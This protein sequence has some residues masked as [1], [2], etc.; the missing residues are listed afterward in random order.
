MRISD[1]SSDVCSSDLAGRTFAAGLRLRASVQMEVM[2]SLGRLG[3]ADYEGSSMRVR[4]EAGEPRHIRFTTAFRAAHPALQPQIYVADLGAAR[5][6]ALMVDSLCVGPLP[7]QF[8]E[9]VP[10]GNPDFRAAHPLRLEGW[11][12]KRGGSGTRGVE[13]EA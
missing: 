4:L 1:W 12:R 3:E 7:P 9:E 5:G 13:G 10:D 2:V 6:A 8:A 11:H